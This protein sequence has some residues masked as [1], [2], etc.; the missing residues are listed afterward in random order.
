MNF[1]NFERTGLEDLWSLHYPSLSLLDFNPN[2]EDLERDRKLPNPTYSP[3]SMSQSHSVES[4]KKISSPNS[5]VI[6]ENFTSDRNLILLLSI[7]SGLAISNVYYN[8]P[9]LAQIG[10]NLQ[11]S[12]S[13]I[14]IVPAV[15]QVGYSIG[16]LLLVPL[17]DRLE[18]RK[19][20]VTVLSLL[21]FAI[22]GIAI[23]PNLTTLTIASLALGCLSIVAQ[24]IIP[25]V[26]QMSSPL[27]RGK[28][29]GLLM[30][31]LSFSLVFARTISGFIGETFGWR[32]IYWL[33]A[34][35]IVTLAITVRGKLPIVPPASQLSYVKL[36]GSILQL[37]REQPILREASLNIALIFGSFNAFWS[38]MIFFLESNYHYDGKVAGLFG[39]VGIVGA[40]VTPLIGRL[41]DEH[42][43][44]KIL[45]Y[46]IA[47]ALTAFT[48]LAIAGTYLSG[49]I[50]GVLFLFLGMHASF[51]LNQIRIYSLVPNAE[52]RL[53][54]V[55]MVTNYTGGAIGSFLGAVGWSLWQWH[56]VCAVA[57]TLIGLAAII[58]FKIFSFSKA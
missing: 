49:L 37:I 38:T 36:M 17:G 45:S 30:S 9:L 26:A 6:E 48:I 31:G 22:I 1:R 53:N 19:L 42:T 7:V 11:V 41:A 29:L 4:P 28:T 52:S 50:I 21:V 18:R 39:L 8:Q 32:S 47:L 58:H 46:A 57:I 44:R 54:T 5:E 3:D 40:L 12:E 43:P 20:I 27:D 2:E 14:G 13:Q 10:R 23:S 16:L 34:G 15:T 35:L 55:Y 25:M 51:I 24:L 33:S 56:G